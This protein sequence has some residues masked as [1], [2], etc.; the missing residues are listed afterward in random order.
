MNDEAGRGKKKEAKVM[1]SKAA[2]KGTACVSTT[3]G[4]GIGGMC[5]TD[6]YDD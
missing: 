4:E 6:A 3:L 1:N 2:D 5:W